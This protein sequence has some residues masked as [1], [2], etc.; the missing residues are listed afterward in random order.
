[1]IGSRA[2]QTIDE[3]AGGGSARA[4]VVW[5]DISPDA[6]TYTI[7][8]ITEAAMAGRAGV[9]LGLVLVPSGA[10]TAAAMDLRPGAARVLGLKKAFSPNLTITAQ[11]WRDW[12]RLQIPAYDA[13]VGAVYDL[14]V[15]GGGQQGAPNRIELDISCAL[16]GAVMS[17]YG[18]HAFDGI[19]GVGGLFRQWM[20]GKVVCLSV[21][22]AGT[23]QAMIS[24]EQTATSQPIGINNVNINTVFACD[25][26]SNVITADTTRDITFAIQAQ[27]LGGQGSGANIVSRQ[28][29]GGRVASINPPPPGRRPRIPWR[30]VDWVALTLSLALGTSIVMILVASTIQI[31]HGSFPQVKLSENATQI[32]IAGTGGLTGLLGAYIGLNRADRKGPPDEPD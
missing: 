26:G 21:G 6:A 5:A 14:E 1:M 18:R 19:A 10:N 29:I 25:T 32:L 2:T 22:T 27:W 8:I 16:N 23:F 13:E 30:P 31:T 20:R 12:A 3:T 15:W 11:T 4:D 28:A 17:A 24:G 7:S 9:Y